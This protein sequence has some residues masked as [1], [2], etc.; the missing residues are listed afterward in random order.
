MIAHPVFPY[1]PIISTG[2]IFDFA[3]QNEFLLESSSSRVA[4]GIYASTDKGYDSNGYW[5]VNEYGIVY[6]WASLPR[7]QS[8]STSTEKRELLDFQHFVSTI[9]ELIQKARFFYE[10][11]EYSGNIEITAHLRQVFKETVSFREFEHPNL[12]G[13]SVDSKV[14]ASTQCLSQELAKTEKFIDIVHKL[15]GKLLWAFNID[16]PL[17]KTTTTTRRLVR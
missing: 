17:R 9:V 1:R 7:M 10:K 6:H 4:G 2:N 3:S 15:A 5:E 16:D 14:L 13:R 12:V 8:W 11:Y